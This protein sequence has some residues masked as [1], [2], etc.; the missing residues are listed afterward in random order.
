MV[1]PGPMPAA[2]LKPS[3]FLM[4]LSSQQNL[5]TTINDKPYLLSS[6]SLYDSEDNVIASLLL[7]TAIDNDFLINSQR[8]G[9]QHMSA[10]AAGSPSRV[11]A[12]N[13][14]DLLPAGTR[15]KLLNDKYV[16][17][18]KDFFDYGGSDLQMQFITF[19]QK[20]QYLLLS[21]SILRKERINRAV[22]GLL[23][24]LSFS[25][26]MI[27]ITKRVQKLTGK[28]MDFSR[29]NLDIIE[30]RADEADE[31]T[32]L[33]SHF[34]KLS[35]EVV[36]SREEL[37]MRVE[38]RTDE[39]AKANAVLAEEIAGRKK[40]EELVKA[41][42]KEKEVLLQEIHHRVKNNMTVITSLL[43]I[44]ANTIEDE[45]YKDIFINSINRIKSMA[46]IH[47]KLYRSAD[48]AKVN[49]EDY[50][51]EMLNNMLM[52]YGLNSQRVALVTEV[53][54]INLRI[55]T[56][57]PCGLIINELV[58]NS[59]KYAFPDDRK[60]EIRVAIRLNDKGRAEVKVSDNGVGIPEELDFRNT[61]S[62]GLNLI[63]ALT[64]QLQGE[65]ELNRKN[66]TEFMIVFG[67]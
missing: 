40:A 25:V 14:P 9:P 10:L 37:E 16:Y 65:I 57:I 19:V 3:S 30:Q 32:V 56:A 13:K 33:E 20:N 22:T 17:T 47:E 67:I 59:L 35:D 66:G 45:Q 29:K 18:G 60:G 1:A 34:Q 61:N 24:I 15:L 63:N 21:E 6:D 5:M 49:F 23:L 64:G 55:D 4:Q 2:F 54:N 8:E 44:Q 52:S 42:L 43:Q 46:L 58:S 39:L 53:E 51:K 28:V 62:M 26:L 12:S 48:F 11:I 7:V 27:W 41:S 50:L 36:S 38:K 31:L